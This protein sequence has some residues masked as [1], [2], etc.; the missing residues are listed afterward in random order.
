VAGARES[1]P[2]RAGA[3]EKRRGM[4]VGLGTGRGSSWAQELWY[5]L[6]RVQLVLQRISAAT[7]AQS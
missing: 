2:D 6:V 4:Y 1:G 7:V 5:S 3:V